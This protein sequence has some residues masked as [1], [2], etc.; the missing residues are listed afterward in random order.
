MKRTPMKTARWL[1]G[2]Q[3]SEIAAACKVSVTTVTRWESG[4]SAI[5]LKN[6]VIYAGLC[7]VAVESLLEPAPALT[8]TGD[9]IPNEA[10]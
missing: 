3:Q 6:A 9:V 1:A 8:G 4:A 5:S 7:G 2:V 10:A